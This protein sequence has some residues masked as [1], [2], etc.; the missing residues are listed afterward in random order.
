MDEL[1]SKLNTQVAEHEV[2]IKNVEENQAQMKEK[3]DDIHRMATSIELIAHDMSYMK[4][5]VSE[6]KDGQSELRSDFKKSQEEIR[7]KFQDI[8]TEPLKKKS[9]FLDFIKDKALVIIVTGL[10]IYILTQLFP[11]I[12]WK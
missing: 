10:I 2:R 6:L 11:Q 4:T 8:E 7:G 3:V 9:S 1:I 5:D 12:N